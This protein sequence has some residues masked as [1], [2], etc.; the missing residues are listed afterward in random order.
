M[1]LVDDIVLDP[2]EI[3]EG[4]VELSLSE[5]GLTVFDADFGEN[6]LEATLVRTGRGQ[7]AVDRRPKPRTV[8]LNI[9]VR[10][11]AEVD[12][13]TAAYRLQQKLGTMQQQGGWFRR[14]FHFE[15]FAGGLLYK[16]TGE[17]TLSGILGW[18]RGDTGDVTLTL[19]CDLV[20][21]STEEEETEEAFVTKVGQRQLLYTVPPSKGTAEGLRRVRIDNE[22]EDDWRALIWAEECRDAPEDLED[23]TAALAY[24]AK[25]LTPKGGAVVKTVSGAEV[26]QHNALTA[27]WVTILSSEIAGVG[28]MSHQGPRRMWMRVEDPS[29]EL[30][31]VQMQLLYRSLGSTRWEDKLP[32]VSSPVVGGYQLVDFG[33]CRPQR[34]VLGSDR[35]EWKLLARATSGAGTIRI[36]DVY[37]LPTEQYLTVREPYVP[38]AADN[39]ETRLP[40]TVEDK[41][42]VGTVAWSNVGNVKA[43]DNSYATCSFSPSLNQH[44]HYLIAKKFNLVLPVGAVVLGISVAV[45]RKAAIPT[46]GARVSDAEVKLMKTGVIGGEDKANHPSSG[47]LSYWHGA[48]ETVSYGG[49]SDL[50]GRTWTASDLNAEDFGVAISVVNGDEVVASIDSV[51]VTA[52]F[53]EE[54]DE[55]KVCFADCAV[56]LRP[57]GVHRQHSEDDVWGRLIEDGFSPY[58]PAGGLEELPTRGILIA[59]VGDLGELPDAATTSLAAGVIDRPGYLF[60]REAG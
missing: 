39:Q 2:V 41:A 56:E 47:Y 37:P 16:V 58:T 32:V 3:D 9:A 34:A 22:G 31:N 30:G 26:V 57:D 14:D 43:S 50:W 19:S 44:S 38:S 8:I 6:A 4:R 42:A 5:M 18:R 40:A 36:R 10:E 46:P 48:E 1:L 20:A 55:S 52:Y 35:W 49:A 17:I 27:G 51:S 33:L 7:E 15:N 45:E 54:P 59:S 23:P 28:H 24:L 60:A 11:D 29:E 53:T 25:N 21:Y 12:L 13:P